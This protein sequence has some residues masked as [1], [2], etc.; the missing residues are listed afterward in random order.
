MT[1]WNTP[2]TIARMPIPDA[3]QLVRR[4]LGLWHPIER[5]ASPLYDCIP[6]ATGHVTDDDLLATAA[7]GI[8]LTASTLQAF[9]DERSA[10]EARLAELPHDVGLADA[11]DDLLH[12]VASA[13]TLTRLEPTT[14]SKLLHRARPRLVPPYDRAVTDWYV[15]GFGVRRAGQLPDLLTNMRAD[16]RNPANSESLRQMQQMIATTRDGGLVPPRLRLLDIAVWMAAN[17]AH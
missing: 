5:W 11:E 13:L 3:G 2:L 8:R 17:A 7:L 10:L 9:A 14:V 4:H 1:T 16:L 15:R 6:R 12:E